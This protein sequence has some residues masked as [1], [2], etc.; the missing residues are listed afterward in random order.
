MTEDILITY[1]D[2]LKKLSIF[3]NA[4]V[5]ELFEYNFLKLTIRIIFN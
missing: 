2:F 1:I 3:N 5:Q 4:Y